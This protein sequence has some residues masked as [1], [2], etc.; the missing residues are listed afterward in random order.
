MSRT[1]VACIG[2]YYQFHA[3]GMHAVQHDLKHVRPLL[4]SH[5]MCARAE[6]H[7]DNGQAVHGDIAPAR[8]CTRTQSAMHIEQHAETSGDVRLV[9]CARA[10]HAARQLLEIDW[11][12]NVG[13]PSMR[14]GQAVATV[15][16]SAL[17]AALHAFYIIKLAVKCD[18]CHQKS[19]S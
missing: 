19:A 15:A 10:S 9:L 14:I 12:V 13:Q 8:H 3:R 6:R 2:R 7:D 17:R 18:V 5:D 4:S 1:R 16:A 11:Y